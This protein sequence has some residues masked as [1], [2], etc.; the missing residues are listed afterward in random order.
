V[1]RVLRWTAAAG[2]AGWLVTRASWRGLDPIEG[3]ALQAVLCV[4]P[5]GV[6]VVPR[7]G[8]AR[9]DAW[10][11]RGAWLAPFAVGAVLAAALVPT[12]VLAAVLAAPWLGCTLGWAWHGRERIVAAARARDAGDACVGFAL[13]CLPIGAGWLVVDRLGATPFGFDSLLVRLTVVHMHYAA[14]APPLLA[15]LAARALE[16]AGLPSRS[17][18]RRLV[19]AIATTLCAGPVVVGAGITSRAAVVTF[20]GTCVVAAGLV[21]LAA[22]TF[23]HVLRCMRGRAA[24]LLLAVSAASALFAM[25]LAV[26]YAFGQAFG[27]SL[28]RFDWMVRLHGYANA[29]GV[30]L[31]GLLAW[32]LEERACRKHGGP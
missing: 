2:A 29:H 12:G 10:L 3:A 22:V 19:A 26:A 18:R 27:G 28:V 14:F 17:T 21:A 24:R 16:R 4:V 25:P 23:T 32:L 7:A 9:T 6:S 1:T 30:A 5:L 15:A 8:A 20:A 11:D 13:L 31:A